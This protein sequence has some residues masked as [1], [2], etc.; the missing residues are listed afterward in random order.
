MSTSSIVSQ[1]RFVSLIV[2]FDEGRIWEDTGVRLFKLPQLQLVYQ[3][4]EQRML[5]TL[6]KPHYYFGH[7]LTQ[8]VFDRSRL[9][10]VYS[11]GV[12]GAYT[13]LKLSDGRFEYVRSF[14]PIKLRQQEAVST[15]KSSDRGAFTTLLDVCRHSSAQVTEAFEP[16]DA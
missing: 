3:L 8:P 4:I 13:R 12:V 9:K 5:G 14:D 2:N 15:G 1:P 7:P 6:S 10:M 16:I 11:M